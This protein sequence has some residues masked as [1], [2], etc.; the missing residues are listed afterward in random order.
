MLQLRD[1]P[2]TDRLNNIW[3]EGVPDDKI[4]EHANLTIYATTLCVSKHGRFFC[5]KVKGKHC[6][7]WYGKWRVLWK[8]DSVL[9][10][11]SL[12]NMEVGSVCD[13]Y[14]QFFSNKVL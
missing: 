4:F 13:M 8:A 12:F 9:K 5:V 1:L 14:R 6:H 11:L 10:A 7:N 3:F 2:S